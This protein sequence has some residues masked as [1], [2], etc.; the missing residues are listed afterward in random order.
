MLYS[1]DNGLNNLICIELKNGNNIV[2]IS[3]GWSKANKVFHMAYPMSDVTR[4]WVA[5][6]SATQL[7]YWKEPKTPHSPEEEG[8]FVSAT[9][10]GISF[11]C[12]KLRE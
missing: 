9:K 4:Q 10:E 11:P 1:Q 12:T 2:E 6:H 7:E 5:T 8:F 3:E